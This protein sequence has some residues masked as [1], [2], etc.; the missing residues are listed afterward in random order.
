MDLCNTKIASQFHQ[1]RETIGRLR[2]AISPNVYLTVDSKKLHPLFWVDCIQPGA[3]PEA[4]PVTI[5]FHSF[6]WT[7]FSPPFPLHI[8]N[9]C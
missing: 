3:V 7:F 8:E 4:L 2:K 9:R 5:S 6:Q 1:S